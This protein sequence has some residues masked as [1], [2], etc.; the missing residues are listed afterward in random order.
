MFSSK[1]KITDLKAKINTLEAELRKISSEHLSLSLDNKRLKDQDEKE[2]RD[3]NIAINF[4]TVPV[5]S[6]DRYIN[7]Y[8]VLVTGMTYLIGGGE[9]KQE[10]KESFFYC[11]PEKHEELIKEFKEYVKK[12]EKE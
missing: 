1:K 8:S 4:N 9:D 11:S 7:K 3:A 2:V 12:R 6:L 10:V 5:I